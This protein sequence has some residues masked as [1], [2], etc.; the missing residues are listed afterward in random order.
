MDFTIDEIRSMIRK[1]SL[2]ESREELNNF[3]S[4][5]S[6]WEILKLGRNEPSHTYFLA[7]FFNCSEF[8]SEI[9]NGPCKKLLV[10]LLERAEKQ[11]L[12]SGYEELVNSFY[13][14]N[15]CITSCKAESEF[16]IE[17][18][19]GKGDEPPYGKGSIDVFITIEVLLNKNTQE[20]RTIHIVIENK[21]DAPETTKWF[22]EDRS[23]SK[24][25]KGAKYTLYQTD[26]YH[27][28]VTDTYPDD[29]NLFV[30]LNP[31]SDNE[32]DKIE[33]PECQNKYYI[34]INY[35][36]LL[37]KIIEPIFKRGNI[38]DTHK[39]KL[40][41]YI[42][43]LSKPSETDTNKKITIM[44]IPEKEKELLVS[45]FNENQDLIRAAITAIGDEELSD[46]LSNIEKDP[47]DR[48]KYSISYNGQTVHNISKSH[49]ASEFVKAY[50]KANQNININ[51]LNNEFTDIRNPFFEQSKSD[52]KK[53]D[54]I[55]I[56]NSKYYIPNNIWAA[57]SIYFTTL[58]KIIKKLKGQNIEVKPE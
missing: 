47:K 17:L 20:K 3:Y 48:T 36:H 21:I 52:D 12:L 55:T 49:L 45:F 38:S 5:Q 51:F 56:N 35:Q 13:N 57:K 54:E 37:D 15:L 58:W 9:N 25:N 53:Y 24:T 43:T 34:Q 39:S 7:W 19:T 32:L 2:N 6:M 31:I 11:G 46:A 29:I 28:F 27:Q 44:A 26:A 4:Y 41:D 1:F 30:F 50:I 40:Y 22:K 23:Q 14:S 10:L 33:E 42:R 8:N 16:P 18:T